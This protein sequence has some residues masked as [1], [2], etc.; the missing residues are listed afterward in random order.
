MQ[1]HWEAMKR[2]A[3][4]PQA[5]K[6]RPAAAMILDAEKEKKTAEQGPPEKDRY[7]CL[8]F[9]GEKRREKL[10]YGKSVV[11]FSPGRYRLMKT[12]GDSRSLSQVQWS[13]N[14]VATALP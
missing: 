12:K 3:A 13:P 6:K 7:D 10:V 11:Y 1:K 5:T 4:S 9:P 14:C 2:P 8:A